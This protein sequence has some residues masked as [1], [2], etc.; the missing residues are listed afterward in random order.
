MSDGE[1]MVGGR[2]L[3]KQRHDHCIQRRVLEQSRN[4]AASRH[5]R[6]EEGTA[7]ERHN[8]ITPLL[9]S[10]CCITQNTGPIAL[11]QATVSCHVSL[12]LT[13]EI[14]RFACAAMQKMRAQNAYATDTHEARPRVERPFRDVLRVQFGVRNLLRQ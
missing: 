9:P 5:V 4:N 2:G 12:T 11:R 8:A 6:L 7:N 3:A 10:E 13:S 14:A 1:A